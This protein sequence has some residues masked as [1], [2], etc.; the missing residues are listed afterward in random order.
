MLSFC[1]WRRGT[2]QLKGGRQR[3]WVTVSSRRFYLQMLFHKRILWRSLSSPGNGLFVRYLGRN[4]RVVLRFGRLKLERGRRSRRWLFGRKRR[5][6]LRRLR[7]R[8]RRQRRLRR[9]RRV[10]IRRNRRR[11]RRRRRRAR[12]RRRRRRRLLRRKRRIRRRKRRSVVKFRFYG[13]WRNAV[14]KGKQFV[15]YVGQ[16]PYRFW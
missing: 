16:R 11:F 14:R 4:R 1:R 5:R 13:K 12:R 8:K 2:W 7:R 6:Y 15:V 3:R 9:K 10:K